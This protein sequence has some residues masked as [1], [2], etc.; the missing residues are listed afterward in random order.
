M[1]MQTKTVLMKFNLVPWRVL[2][3]GLIVLPL[4]LTGHPGPPV[5]SLVFTISPNADVDT[6]LSRYERGAIL[7]GEVYGNPDAAKNLIESL[8]DI[9]PDMGRFIIEF[10][11]GDI[12]SRPGLD[13]KS[14]EIAT[15][16][17]LTAMGNAKPQL[18]THIRASLNVGLTEVEIMECIIQM[19]LYAGFPASLN[20]IQAAREVFGE[21]D[22]GAKFRP[23]MSESDQSTR[24]QRGS[25]LLGE[26]Y[27]NPDAA[28]N[29]VEGLRDIAPDMA[30]FIIEFPYGDVYSRPG[31]DM[32]LREIATVAALTALGTAKPQLQTHIRASLNIGLT[33]EEITEC[34]IQMALYAGFPASLNG[35]QA[36]KEVFKE[37]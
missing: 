27:G 37:Q 32:K 21:S 1:F 9:A 6:T 26:V 24:Y 12:Y 36:A 23:E 29:M 7:I 34:I 13:M 4:T 33:E 2:L 14:R 5:N 16:A 3:A 15:V 10:P 28:K 35:L 17:A 25:V 19:S 20:A 18:Q 31:L 30:R 8:R 11:Y 22:S